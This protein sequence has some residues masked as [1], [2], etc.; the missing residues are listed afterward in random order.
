MSSEFKDTSKLR[1]SVITDMDSFEG[2]EAEWNGIWS[3]SICTVFSS[4][5]WAKASIC[6]FGSGR[7]LFLPVV[8]NDDK[9][10]GILPMC[11]LETGELTFIGSPRSDYNDI[12]CLD[13]YGNAVVMLAIQALIDG[14]QKCDF[15][16]LPQSSK[17]KRW[18]A[19]SDDNLLDCHLVLSKNAVCPRINLKKNPT[20]FA[21]LL[22]KKSMRRNSNK[23]S[24]LGS[25]TFRHISNRCEIQEHLP[26]FYQQ[27]INRRLMSGDRSLFLNHDS[28]DFYDNLVCSLDS[29]SILRFGVV[30]LDSR[31]IAYHFGFQ[32]NGV[33]Y[34]YKP[35]FDID[36]WEFS[37]GEVL[38]RFLLEYSVENGIQVF[39]FTVG[40][41]TFKSRFANDLQQNFSIKLYKKGTQ[42][43]ERLTIQLNHFLKRYPIVHSLFRRIKGLAISIAKKT[44]SSI[45]KHGFVRSFQIVVAQLFA[46]VVYECN[47]VL[48]YK[49]NS[50]QPL[51][52]NF[53]CCVQLGK[54]SDV[55]QLAAAYPNIFPPTR[56]ERFRE[57]LKNNSSLWITKMDNQIVHVAWTKMDNKIT[58]KNQV[59]GCQINLSETEQ[60][61]SD[62]WTPQKYRGHGYYSKTLMTL[63]SRESAMNSWIYCQADNKASKSG[64]EKAG[65]EP[66][67]YMNR[68]KIL[69]F[70]MRHD[71]KKTIDP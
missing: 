63:A 68:K 47:T 33:F 71:I 70:L 19:E 37:P 42:R 21:E 17:I 34:W 54:L 57:R 5:A 59:G 69:G 64:I 15:S 65:F 27:H 23:L 12:V 48:V 53:S 31:P 49:S 38:L 32:S 61:I 50:Q 4:Y 52:S 67:A 62:C 58:D 11:K 7:Q 43:R 66:A 8:K 3:K 51:D 28:Q 22:K 13:E 41:E 29:Q 20:I 2:L 35:T 9:V 6:T 56:L 55:V 40:N 18:L 44:A 39:D 26:Q 24:R 16:N 60:I 25:L 36:Y 1:V 14:G 30:E 45:K 10:V 46:V